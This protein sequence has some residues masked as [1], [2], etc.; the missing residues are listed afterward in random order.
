MILAGK[1]RVVEPH[2]HIELRLLEDWLGEV[3]VWFH[4]ERIPNPPPG[5]AYE[6]VRRYQEDEFQEQDERPRERVRP[7]LDAT[8]KECVSCGVRRYMVGDLCDACRSQEQ[9]LEVKRQ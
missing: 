5:L 3:L 7:V 6:E 9:S 2:R 1:L 8:V 4:Q